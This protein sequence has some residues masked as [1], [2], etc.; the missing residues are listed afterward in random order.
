MPLVSARD[1]PGIFAQPDKSGIARGLQQAFTDQRQQQE[2]Q[3]VEQIQVAKDKIEQFGFQ[4]QTALGMDNL[5]RK[6]KFLAQMGQRIQREGGDLSE[7]NRL[8]AIENVDELN[9]ALTQIATAAAD[10]GER[11]GEALDKQPEKFE[12]LTDETGKIIGQRSLRT[13]KVISDPRAVTDKPLTA[14][15]K[16]RDDLKRGFISQADFN[17]LKGT[18]KKFQTDVGKLIADK[19]LAIEMFGADSQQAQAIQSAID[20]DQKGE[21]PKLTDISGIRKEFTKQ[22]GD[23]IQMRDAFNKIQ[24]ASNTG[25]GDVSLIFSFM[26]II[27]PGSTVREGEFATAEETA[28]IPTRITNLYNKALEGDRLGQEQ[29]D[30]FK[31]EAGNLFNAQLQTQR[32]LEGVFR[33]LATRQDIDPANVVLDFVGEIQAIESVVETDVVAQPKVGDLGNL[34]LEEL[35]EL[36]AQKEAGL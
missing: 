13:G 14:L 26:K 17:S 5:D 25:P 8:M 11:L 12:T 29:R 15:G 31:S 19:Q 27:D 2:T 9:L 20:S 33:S 24:S 34:S 7:V 22:S 28:G 35:I 36:K 30:A 21:P 10:G 6:K 4:A 32:Q 1:F 3:R 16:A 23:F 18:P